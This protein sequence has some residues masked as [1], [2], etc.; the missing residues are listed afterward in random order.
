LNGFRW[1]TRRD[2]AVRYAS[3]KYDLL[4]YLPAR[5]K[6]ED[7]SFRLADIESQ[8]AVDKLI[9]ELFHETTNQVFTTGRLIAAVKPGAE[10]AK[11][12]SIISFTADFYRFKDRC[13]K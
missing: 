1:Q 10:A 12:H 6:P 13:R 11:T 2:W 7:D 5:F 4:I 9:R 3:C 8:A